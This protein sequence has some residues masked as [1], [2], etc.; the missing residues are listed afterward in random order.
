MTIEKNLIKGCINQESHAQEALY[1]LHAGKM[2]GICYRYCGNIDEAEDALQRG[3]ID[4]FK[5]IHQ[6]DAQDSFEGW[7]RLKMIMASIELLKTNKHFHQTIEL[8]EEE[9]FSYEPIEK[10]AVLHNWEI[11]D[12]VKSLPVSFR[13]VINLYSIDGMDHSKIASL[14]NISESTSRAQYARAR[15]LLARILNA[16]GRIQSIDNEFVTIS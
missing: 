6:F 16:K 9:N 3:F 1:N 15:I 4:A 13:M 5:N 12:T 14:L 2:L 11:I 10:D 7:L 8:S